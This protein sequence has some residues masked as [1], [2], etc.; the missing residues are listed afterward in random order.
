[1]YC[2]LRPSLVCRPGPY[3]QVHEGPLAGPGSGYQSF[4][5]YESGVTIT[6]GSRAQGSRPTVLQQDVAQDSERHPDWIKTIASW[7][8]AER[9]REREQSS[10]DPNCVGA[11][12]G[13][14]S[15]S[16]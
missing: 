4:L 1:M 6:L 13:L 9:E 7:R 14:N 8:A 10:E 3:D 16:P 2:K 5:Q 11:W 15:P 12:E